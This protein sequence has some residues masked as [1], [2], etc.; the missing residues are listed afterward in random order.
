MIRALFLLQSH[1]LLLLRR[2]HQIY[3][4]LNYHSHPHCPH[5]HYL[6]IYDQM[7][8]WLEIPIVVYLI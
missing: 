2:H 4:F 8:N 5:H 6:S 7:N 1:Q 3:L